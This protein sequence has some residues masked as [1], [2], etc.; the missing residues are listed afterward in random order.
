MEQRSVEE[1][2]ESNFPQLAGIMT[3]FD[4]TQYQKEINHSQEYYAPNN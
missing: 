1:K 4:A 2:E 3:S